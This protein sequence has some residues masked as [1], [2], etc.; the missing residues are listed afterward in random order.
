MQLTSQA[1]TRTVQVG[2]QSKAALQ[3]ELQRNAIALNE[4][5]EQLFASERFTT[6]AARYAVV[7]AE[8]SVGALAQ[9][10]SI[11]AVSTACSGCAATVPVRITSGSPTISSSFA[12]HDRAAG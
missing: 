4:S 11:C 12:R 9:R 1:I 6:A 5:A 2:G 8:L 10:A 7:T 3:E